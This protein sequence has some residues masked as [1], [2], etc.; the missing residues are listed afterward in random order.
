MDKRKKRVL[1]VLGLGSVVLLW[2]VYVICTKYLPSSA[3]A[4]PD[5]AVVDAPVA[6]PPVV[7]KP[8]RAGGLSEAALAIR[9][10]NQAQ[11]ADRSFGR[12]PF[13]RMERPAVAGGVAQ[14]PVQRVAEQAP[15]APPMKIVG[16]SAYDGD[17]IAA[18]NGDVYR[19]GDKTAE[20]FDVGRIT[21]STVTLESNGWAYIY[22]LGQTE[23][24]IVRID[25]GDD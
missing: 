23:P 11:V 2:R 6:P 9:L 12:D 1:T 8:V 25:R 17:W 16:V 14:T 21:R 19:V 15:P 24:R 5:S 3:Q 4:Q 20:G 10:E 22:S 13:A 18:M 7:T